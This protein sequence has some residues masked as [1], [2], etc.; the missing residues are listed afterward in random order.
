MK[1]A[2]IKQKKV[3]TMTKGGREKLGILQTDVGTN[4]RKLERA[5]GP[6]VTYSSHASSFSSLPE[7]GRS[8]RSLSSNVNNVGA[9]RD[10]IEEQKDFLLDPRPPNRLV[11]I[12]RLLT[13]ETY[14]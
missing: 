12:Q 10:L 7:V 14:D 5:V 2:I 8:G 13:G 4:L 11:A 9:L 1:R 3:F 6:Y